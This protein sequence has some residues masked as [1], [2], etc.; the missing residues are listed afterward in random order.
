M[1][2]FVIY[3]QP[4]NEKVTERLQNIGI[5]AYCPL[6]TQVRQ[7]WTGKEGAGAAD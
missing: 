7:W 4:R 3:T 2:W 6:V 1:P 5:T